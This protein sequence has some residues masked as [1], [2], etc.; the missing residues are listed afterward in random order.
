MATPLILHFLA[1]AALWM[2]RDVFLLV[3]LA[4]YSL[5]NFSGLTTVPPRPKVSKEH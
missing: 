2:H 4:D 3:L 5:A 1:K